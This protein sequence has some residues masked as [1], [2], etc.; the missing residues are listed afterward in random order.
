MSRLAERTGGLNFSIVSAS[1]AQQAAAKAGVALRNQYL[2]GFKPSEDASGTL[3][4]IKVRVN[5]ADVTVH[6][7]NG[8]RLP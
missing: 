1:E 5:L 7:R 4:T 3:H 2:V 6:S 8:Y